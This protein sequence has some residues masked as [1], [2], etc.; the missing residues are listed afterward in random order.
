VHTWPE[1]ELQRGVIAKIGELQR[2][3][4]HDVSRCGIT[5]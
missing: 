5:K 1:G 2:A 3:N 4:D